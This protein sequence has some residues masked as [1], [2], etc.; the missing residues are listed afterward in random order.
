MG[1]RWETD[2]GECGLGVGLG[3]G[4]GPG[5]E[6]RA[7]LR[8][9][10]GLEFRRRRSGGGREGRRWMPVVTWRGGWYKS[11]GWRRWKLRWQPQAAH[12]SE[13]GSER[14]EEG[15]GMNSPQPSRAWPPM[16]AA[17]FLRHSR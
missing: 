10:L 4:L 11:S 2:G 15:E 13:V 3:V 7:G 8:L 1:G 16:V 12:F 17:W 5:L 9:G 6:L 14:R